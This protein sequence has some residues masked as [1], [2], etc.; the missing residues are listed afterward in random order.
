MTR[1]ELLTRI[2]FDIIDYLNEPFDNGND[3]DVKDAIYTLYELLKENV[4][5][6]TTNGRMD[7]TGATLMIDW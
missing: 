7:G 6:Y 4:E 5:W 1:N 3:R 2:N